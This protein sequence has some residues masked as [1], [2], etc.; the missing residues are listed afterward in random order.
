METSDVIIRLLLTVVLTGIIGLERQT[1]H[2]GA[3][4]RTYIIVGL[5][6]ALLMMLSLHIP[7]MYPNNAAI[8]PA[9]IAAQIVVGIGFIGAGV[10][11]HTRGSSSQEVHGITTASMIWVASAIGMAVGAGFYFP[12][13]FVAVLSLIILTTLQGLKKK[14][15]HQ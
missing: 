2:T 11:I 7:E 12:A 5:G 4:I 15:P 6:S 9:R 1:R 3:G 8:D 13:V 10:I 14:W